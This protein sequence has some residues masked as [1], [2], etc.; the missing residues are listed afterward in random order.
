LSKLKLI[1][2]FLYY[3]LY[4]QNNLVYCL[5]MLVQQ[6]KADCMRLIIYINITLGLYKSV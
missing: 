3:V 4:Q 6:H 1:I 2:V 5:S